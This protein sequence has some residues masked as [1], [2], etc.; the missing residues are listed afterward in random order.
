MVEERLQKAGAEHTPMWVKG[1]SGI[2]GNVEADRV[3]RKIGW[4]GTWWGS[5]IPPG[6]P[7]TPVASRLWSNSQSEER[8]IKTTSYTPGN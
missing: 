4:I 1:H 2:N 6:K 5:V 8:K 7:S 3:A